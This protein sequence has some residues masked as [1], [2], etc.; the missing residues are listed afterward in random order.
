VFNNTGLLNV[1]SGVLALANGGTSTG[2]FQTVAGGT[3]SFTGGTYTLNAGTTLAGTGT[4]LINNGTLFVNAAISS[5]SMALSNGALDGPGNLT[6]T[7]TFDWTG[8]SLQ[9][10]TGKLAIPVGATLLIRGNTDKNNS[11]RTINLSGTATWTDTGSFNSGSNAVLNVLASGVFNIQADANVG[12][13]TWNNFGTINKTTTPG[14]TSIS[15][16]N[17]FTN[18][19]NINVQSGTLDV[20][21]TYKQLNGTTTISAGAALIS[22]FDGHINITGGALVGNGNVGSSTSLANVTNSG[23]V[24]PGSPLGTLNIFGTYTQTISGALDIAIGGTT[25][26]TQYDRLAVTGAVTLN[27]TLNVSLANGFVPAFGNVFIPL[28][29]ASRTGTFAGVTG[30]AIP[31]ALLFQTSTPNANNFDLVVI[32]NDLAQ[33]FVWVGHLY[34]DLLGRTASDQEVVAWVNLV[35]AGLSRQVIVTGFVNSPE[36]RVREVQNIYQT[37]LHRAADPTGLNAFVSAIQ[38][39]HAPEEVRLAIISSLEYFQTHGNSNQAYVSALYNDI[40][41]RAADSNG[42]AGFTGL[43]NANQLTRAQVASQLFASLE[44]RLDVVGGFYTRF[45]RRTGDATSVN[46][47]ANM[48]GT[49]VREDDVIMELI[50]SDEY[51]LRP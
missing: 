32:R 48:L 4:F 16:F 19:G 45:L 8:G 31:G 7:G 11:A 40:L 3:V 5:P 29:F 42:L 35:G 30:T 15:V 12:G 22:S 49:G 2:Q 9:N 6:V 44:Y 47:F 21:G 38:Q 14:T 26:G 39:G 51:F 27:G 46:A 18:N 23:I 28:T 1:V 24:V 36:Y 41:H 33:V 20:A 43:L 25:P 13:G 50:A 10:S 34:Q 17:N 37:L